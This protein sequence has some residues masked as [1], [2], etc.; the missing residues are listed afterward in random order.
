VVPFINTIALHDHS[1]TFIH[2][3]VSGSIRAVKERA[4]DA[5]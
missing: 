1:R 3:F 4:M 5:P 2:G